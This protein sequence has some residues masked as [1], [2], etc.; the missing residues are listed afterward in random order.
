MDNYL[1]FTNEMLKMIFRVNEIFLKGILL[2]ILAVF[3]RNYQSSIFSVLLT[4]F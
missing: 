4:V 2:L 1:F 3:L